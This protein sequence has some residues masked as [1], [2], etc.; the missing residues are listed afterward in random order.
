MPGTEHFTWCL[1]WLA[2]YCGPFLRNQDLL[3]LLR[4]QLHSLAPVLWWKQFDNLCR[5]EK[6]L[7][8]AYKNTTHM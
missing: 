5:R 1:W 3:F 4:C 2:P 6:Y 7:K 8:T